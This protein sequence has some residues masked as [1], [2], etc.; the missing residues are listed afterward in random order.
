VWV[1]GGREGGKTLFTFSPHWWC[2]V[3][4][5]K[6]TRRRKKYVSIYL[7]VYFSVRA[8][9]TQKGQAQPLCPSLLPCFVCLAITIFKN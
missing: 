3:E 9:A 6:G 4:I 8:P 2:L 1:E 5:E 7:C